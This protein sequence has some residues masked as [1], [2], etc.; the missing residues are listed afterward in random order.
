[1]SEF[2]LLFFPK[3]KL[4]FPFLSKTVPHKHTNVGRMHTA[5]RLKEIIFI[6]NLFVPLTRAVCNSEGSSDTIKSGDANAQHKNSGTCSIFTG[7][8]DK[9]RAWSSS[10]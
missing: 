7:I 8:L 6:K 10:Q 2:S 5:I 4:Q 9:F 3:I 1:M